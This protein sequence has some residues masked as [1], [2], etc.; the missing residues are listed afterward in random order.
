LDVSGCTSLAGFSY[1][2]GRLTTLDFS[3]C[4]ALE[5]LE[6]YNNRLTTLD[7]SGCTSLQELECQYNQLTTLD[8]SGCTALKR[9]HC[10]DNRL[11]REIS[12]IFAELDDF[13]YDRRYT[14]YW[15]DYDG[16]W[17]WT[18]NDV[19]WWYPGEPHSGPYGW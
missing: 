10:Y 8:A 3:G 1:T 12:G 7:V 14:D 13:R 6:C 4:T 16:N 18:E 15:R 11:T 9:L 19:G 17:H 2:R 5:W